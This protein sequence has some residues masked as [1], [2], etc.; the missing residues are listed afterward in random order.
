MV[1]P[2][3]L[4]PGSTKYGKSDIPDICTS[5]MVL[6]IEPPERWDSREQKLNFYSAVK[7]WTTSV[8]TLLV[9]RSEHIRWR[10]NKDI[11]GM[12]THKIAVVTIDEIPHILDEE[13]KELNPRLWLLNSRYR[14]DFRGA[15]QM[16]LAMTSGLHSLGIGSSAVKSVALKEDAR[17]APGD[18]TCVSQQQL[19][20]NW[21]PFLDIAPFSCE[22]LMVDARLALPV[23][24][25]HSS[26]WEL[27]PEQ[28]V[29]A[30]RNRAYIAVEHPT[31][32]R[33]YRR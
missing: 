29:E 15:A 5:S 9:V 10:V 25:G 19:R 26:L 14:P 33:G 27:R 18:F 31:S 23:I 11:Y 8:W 4:R 20:R 7:Q 28:F 1:H 22:D 17:V 30:A 21:G 12:A 16:I 6:C 2:H 3:A 24:H 32:V 13:I